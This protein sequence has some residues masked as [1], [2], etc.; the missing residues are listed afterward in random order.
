[1]LRPT[2]WWWGMMCVA[3]LACGDEGPLE[4]PTVRA[5]A[6]ELEFVLPGVRD[7]FVARSETFVDG[8][9]SSMEATTGENPAVTESYSAPFIWTTDVSARF[10]KDKLE[11]SYSMTGWGSGYTMKPS[12]DLLGADGAKVPASMG[13]GRSE[14][15]FY[16]WRFKPAVAGAIPLGNTCGMRAYLLV[17]FEARLVAKL[18]QT[19]REQTQRSASA[20]GEACTTPTDGSGGGSV[21]GGTRITICTWEVWT[22]LDGVVYEVFDRGCI[23]Y[24]VPNEA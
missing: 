24:T 1:M 10:T 16:P 11:Y 8:A 7:G 5:V 13:D 23:S 21:A 12:L 19:S 4:G 15:L 9:R 18:L 20:N 17:N 22:D 6:R 2:R 14:D 3:T